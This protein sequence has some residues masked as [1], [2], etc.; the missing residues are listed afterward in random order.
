MGTHPIFESDFDCL[1]EGETMAPWAKTIEEKYYIPEEWM[2]G[3]IIGKKGKTLNIIKDQAG[4]HHVYMD[5]NQGFCL[6]VGDSHSI[7]KA[8]EVINELLNLDPPASNATSAS[9]QS[10]NAPKLKPKPKP[11][12]VKK[13]PPMPTEPKP[14]GQVSRFSLLTGPNDSKD[15]LS[16]SQTVNDSNSDGD[17]GPDRKNDIQKDDW[18]PRETKSSKKK[19]K[20]RKRSEKSDKKSDNSEKKSEQQLPT[21]SMKTEKNPVCQKETSKPTPKPTPET[22]IVNS[23]LSNVPSKKIK[24]SIPTK[25]I[26]PPHCLSAEEDVKT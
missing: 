15:E 26:P 5:I 2:Y 19:K 20:E 7:K 23:Q 11:Q 4:L 17:I 14:V 12:I 10:K 3:Q 25:I 1:T 16:D 24:K 13:L 22:I 18:L 8:K 21:K 9:A 6:L